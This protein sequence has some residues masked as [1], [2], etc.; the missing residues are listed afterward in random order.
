MGIILL[1]E[2]KNA[3]IGVWKITESLKTLQLLLPNED[4]SIFSN[5]KRQ[6]EWLATR[7]LLKKIAE[8]VTISYN[9]FG[10]SVLSNNKHASISHSKGLVSIIISNKKVGIDIE[11]ITSKALQ[12]SS[13]FISKNHDKTLSNEKATLIWCAKEAIYKW[14][15]KRGINFIKDIRVADIILEEYGTIIAFFKNTRINLQYMKIDD[16]YLVYVCK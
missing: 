1:K 6:L 4:I 7:I 14:Y 16:Y 11:K 9:S 5:K 8:D 15:Q 13:K 3:T 12:L 2:V 10:A